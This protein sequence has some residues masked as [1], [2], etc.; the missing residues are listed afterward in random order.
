MP[1]PST[2]STSRRLYSALFFLGFV[3]VPASLFGFTGT[4]AW[5][6][7]LSPLGGALMAIGIIGRYENE[8][9]SRGAT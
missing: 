1:T 7:L 9:P 2:T 4:V 6:A 5:M 3:L 8:G